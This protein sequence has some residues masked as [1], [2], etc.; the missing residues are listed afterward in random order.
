MEPAAVTARVA[1]AL[2][3]YEKGEP[4]PS[5]GIA[6]RIVGLPDFHDLAAEMTQM[7][8]HLDKEWSLEL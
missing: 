8:L 1:P 4:K 6:G 3:V 2:D 5:H 7:R